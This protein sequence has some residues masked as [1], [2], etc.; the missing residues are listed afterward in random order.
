VGGTSRPSAF[1]VFRLMTSSM[2]VGNST[3]K[4]PALVPRRILST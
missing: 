2:L 3:G 1:A 4:S